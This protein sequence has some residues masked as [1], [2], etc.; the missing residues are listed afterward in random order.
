MNINCAFWIS[1]MEFYH[2]RRPWKAPLV[3]H[4]HLH[5]LL[6]IQQVF[7]AK[8][9]PCGGRVTLVVTFPFLPTCVLSY[10]LSLAYISHQKALAGNEGNLYQ[11]FIYWASVRFRQCMRQNNASRAAGDGNNAWRGSS[12]AT[13]RSPKDSDYVS[14]ERSVYLP[15]VKFCSS[16]LGSLSSRPKRLSLEKFVTVS[17]SMFR[18]NTWLHRN[19]GKYFGMCRVRVRLVCKVK[20]TFMGLH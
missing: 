1:K 20:G 3:F 11:G 6:R 17:V 4:L 7:R 16:P 5:L 13:E 19:I 9:R 10:C 15:T 8:P 12:E 2:Q 14:A 18:M